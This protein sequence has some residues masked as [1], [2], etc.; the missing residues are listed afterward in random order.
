[1][2]SGGRRLSSLSSGKASRARAQND[3]PLSCWFPGIILIQSGAFVY[4]TSALSH[5]FSSNEMWEEERVHQ[6]RAAQELHFPSER[7]RNT[8]RLATHSSNQGHRSLRWLYSS[9]RATR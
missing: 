5:Q 6:V 7:P 3:A 4:A 8:A 2:S 1:M 9:P